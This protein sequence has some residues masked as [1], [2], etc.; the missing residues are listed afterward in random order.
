[1]VI[2]QS[3][4]SLPEGRLPNPAFGMVMVYVSRGDGIK[5][6]RELMMIFMD[7]IQ[8]CFCSQKWYRPQRTK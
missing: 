5:F 3:Y 6:L 7:S 2:F 8:A 1:M 4:V